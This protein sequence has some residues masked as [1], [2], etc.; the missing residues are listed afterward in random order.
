[1]LM[2]RMLAGCGVQ[3]PEA[4]KLG[5]GSAAPAGESTPDGP[6]LS[7]LA[8]YLAASSSHQDRM[9]VLRRELVHQAYRIPCGELSHL[10]VEFHLA[11]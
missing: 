7:L 6:E 11:A 2:Q 4:D 9:R 3:L 1:M 8:S 10:I 5:S